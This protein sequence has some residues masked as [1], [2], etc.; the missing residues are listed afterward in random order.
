MAKA[1][2]ERKKKREEE[3]RAEDAKKSDV[4]VPAEPEVMLI[5]ALL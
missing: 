4:T 3:R 5:F 1:D 2:D